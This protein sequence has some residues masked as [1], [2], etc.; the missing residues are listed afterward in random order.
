MEQIK[1]KR[2]PWNKG[3]KYA[4]YDEPAAKRFRRDDEY[5][6][7]E[8]EANA[9]RRKE[10]DYDGKR[11]EEIKNNHKKR[12]DSVGYATP[13]RW[14]QEEVEILIENKHNDYVEIAK[15]LNRSLS[16]IEH[17]ISRLGQRKYNKW[18]IK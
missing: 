18:D 10:K 5:R 7:K 3:L 16:S 6:I 9:I 14:T 15:L 17:K 8:L 11:Y 12:R 1:E 4:K 13:R 2:I